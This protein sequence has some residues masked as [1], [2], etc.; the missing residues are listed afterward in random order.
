MEDEEVERFPRSVF[1]E[2]STLGIGGLISGIVVVPVVGMAVVDPFVKDPKGDIDLGSLDDFPE[3]EFVIAT[4]LQD[5]EEGEVSRRT[6]YVRNNGTKDGQPSL[7]IVSNRC[8]H[9]GCPVQ[10][11]GLVLDEQK[12]EVKEGEATL[13]DEGQGPIAEDLCPAPLHQPGLLRRHQELGLEQ[14]DL[15]VSLTEHALLPGHGGAS[16]PF[17]PHYAL[18]APRWPG[19]FTR[20]SRLPADQGWYCRVLGMGRGYASVVS[21][22]SS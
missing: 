5:P 17:R 13:V 22:S 16:R 14:A 4:F 18:L 19:V 7:T 8:V 9:L 10:V 6:V 3:G 21:P 12:K 11:N 2:L 1:L 15:G 20:E